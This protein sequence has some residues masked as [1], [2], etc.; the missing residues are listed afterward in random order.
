M[1]VVK[2]WEIRILWIANSDPMIQSTISELDTQF[3]QRD[4]YLTTKASHD[5]VLVPTAIEVGWWEEDSLELCFKRTNTKSDFFNLISTLEN[6]LK[7]NGASCCL[8]SHCPVRANE[9]RIDNKLLHWIN[10]SVIN[11][12]RPFVRPPNSHSD[13]LSNFQT[14]IEM[15]DNLVSK[16]AIS[17]ARHFIVLVHHHHS[18]MS[19]YADGSVII[20]YQN[21]RPYPA[22]SCLT[23]TSIARN[24]AIGSTASAFINSFDSSIRWNASRVPF[25]YIGFFIGPGTA[26]KYSLFVTSGRITRKVNGSS[27]GDADKFCRVCE[28]PST[29]TTLWTWSAS[30]CSSTSTTTSQCLG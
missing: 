12:W 9:A 13:H 22:I 8:E 4:T 24:W 1:V 10:A 25:S 26:D 6:T 19:M 21:V 28:G 27:A 29:G 11:M 5:G 23:R 30:F 15:K 18:R 14:L 3:E 16:T 7:L 2:A 17:E 20:G